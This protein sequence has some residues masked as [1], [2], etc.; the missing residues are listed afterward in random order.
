MSFQV[1]TAHIS[2]FTN[3]MQLALAQ[4]VSKLSPYALQY[5]ASGKLFEMTNLIGSTLPQRN[6]TRF[7]QTKY[8]DT[9]HARRWLPKTPEYYFAELVDTEDQLVSGID[10]QGGYTMSGAGTIGRSRDIA[11][12]EGFYGTNLTGETGGT[13]TPFAAGN[14]VPVDV[15]AGAATGLN[16]AKLRES[17]RILRANL[18][19]L[20]AEECFMAVTAEQVADLQAQVEVTSADF[21]K[22]DKPVLRDGKLTKLLGFNFIEMEYANA[23]SVGADIVALTTESA[24][25][26]RVPFW[27]R[28][29]MGFGVWGTSASIDKLPQLQMAVQVWAGIHCSAARTEEGKCGQVLCSEV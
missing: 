12:L 27:A 18:V 9:P 13:Q 2:K 14:I 28:S 29:G 25:V 17:Q 8:N 20:D 10:L 7:G 15:G 5:S 16:I 23:A 21:N 4:T 24:N 22:S 26:R 1:T 11:F 3:N 19:D 6:T